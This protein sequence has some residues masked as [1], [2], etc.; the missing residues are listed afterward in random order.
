LQR[1]ASDAT[2][3]LVGCDSALVRDV[4]TSPGKPLDP[5]AR[6][7]MEPRFGHD[8]ANVRIHVDS[9]AAESA[10]SVDAD[11]YTIGRDIAFGAGRFAP[12]TRTGRRLLAHEL[13]HVLQQRG[14]SNLQTS[15]KVSVSRPEDAAEREADR[16]ADLVVSYGGVPT[17]F[18]A[19]SASL[20][21][22]APVAPAKPAAPAKISKKTVTIQ[23]VA[24][25]N[26]DGKSPTAIPSFADAKTIWGKCCVNLTVRA[27]KQVDKA[28]YKELEAPLDCAPKV[29]AL[30]LATAAG[31]S[32]KVISV[33][34]P[35]TFKDGGTTGKDV[36]GGGFATDAG[37]NNPK[38]FVV[39][40]T[41][42]TV[43]AHELGHAM[44]HASCL[45]K[46]GHDPAGTVMSPSGA[47][48]S[49]VA[50]K[51]ASAVC[52]NVRGFGGAVDSGKANC[53]EDLT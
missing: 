2:G 19:R 15:S 41:D 38:V 22:Q 3:S 48:N 43:V 45:G 47:H 4:V 25:A 13:T 20:Q 9:K 14:V 32:G 36:H 23:P 6:S 1:L 33:F 18:F 39:S 8:F 24:V 10:R 11:A 29:E 51:V 30:S 26:D 42:G 17:R 49:P 12:E 37:T 53:S 27:T 16:T 34:V 28:A 46:S 50:K 40:G 44:G 5:G 7:M 31:V 21:R 52:A 35:D